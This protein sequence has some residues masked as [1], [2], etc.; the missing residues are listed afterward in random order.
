MTK[1]KP[2]IL[3]IEDDPFLAEIYATKFDEEGFRV[4]FAKD[5]A[6]GWK[7]LSEKKEKPDL[8]ILD[9]ILPK[10]DGFEILKRIIKDKSLKEMPVVLLTNLGQDEEIERGLRDHVAAYMVKAHFTP[11]EIVHKIREILAEKS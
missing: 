1:K 9:L 6:E 7:M 4:T 8:L 11:G 3:I 5:G 10:L 2:A